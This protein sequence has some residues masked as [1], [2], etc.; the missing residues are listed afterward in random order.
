[1]GRLA[2]DL[3]VVH[4]ITEPAAES[5]KTKAEDSQPWMNGTQRQ[6]AVAA[7]ATTAAG[8]FW[9][10]TVDCTCGCGYLGGAKEQRKGEALR[11]QY[12]SG[13]PRWV[14]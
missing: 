1:M 10:V 7:V 4:G 3:A 9:R 6:S 14:K 11:E 5:P 12:L 8:M 2:C 13:K